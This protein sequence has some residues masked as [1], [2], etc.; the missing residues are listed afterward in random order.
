MVIAKKNDE[1]LD[2]EL[3]DLA[4]PTVQAKPS[5]RLDPQIRPRVDPGVD[6]VDENL[7][8]LQ[9]DPW[10]RDGGLPPRC[11]SCLPVFP[12]LVANLI[13]L[14]IDTVDLLLP[15]IIRQ[16]ALAFRRK[17]I[18]T[19][20]SDFFPSLNRMEMFKGSLALRFKTLWKFRS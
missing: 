20:N 8:I 11:C 4:F 17:N 5:H 10:I 15:L 13:A 6:L 16:P 3:F 7:C 14:C 2:E 18:L 19:S 1:R 9:S 12:H